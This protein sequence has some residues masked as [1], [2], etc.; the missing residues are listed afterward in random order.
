M[1]TNFGSWMTDDVPVPVVDPADI[2]K[3]W[4]LQDQSQKQHPGEQ[5]GIDAELYRDACS[6]GA[7]VGAVW[8]RLSQLIILRLG[9][10]ATGTEPPWL[11]PEPHDAVFK[12][13]ATMPLMGMP[14][15]GYKLQ[16][17]ELEELVALVQKEYEASH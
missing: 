17:S 14:P 11:Q 3:V 2:K 9:S 12:V 1:T 8:Y 4:A 7:N 15:G 13:L 6:P 10:Q 16:S 5:V